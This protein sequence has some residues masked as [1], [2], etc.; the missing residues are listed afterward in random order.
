ME[1]QESLET[2]V[3]TSRSAEPRP[4]LAEEIQGRYGS[5]PGVIRLPSAAAVV[6]RMTGWE[7]AA[8]PLLGDVRKRWTSTERGGLSGA[9]TLV[10]EA[11]SSVNPPAPPSRS[12]MGNAA[13]AGRAQPGT[14]AIPA[15]VGANLLQA[16][17]TVSDTARLKTTPAAPAA[18]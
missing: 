5:S 18:T 12:G 11:G 17:S 2:A 9:P 15:P 14:A 3:R 13:I 7:K 16:G 10:F 1:I 4:S 6:E 8:L